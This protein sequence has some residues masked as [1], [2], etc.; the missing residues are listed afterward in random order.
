MAGARVP[1]H[2]GPKTKTPVGEAFIVSS[3]DG[4]PRMYKI[5]ILS[6]SEKQVRVVPS[7]A[8]YFRMNYETDVFVRHFAPSRDDAIVRW[9]AELHTEIDDYKQ[10]IKLREKQ[11][12]AM[13]KD[14]A[15]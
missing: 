14:A 10:Q 9:Q 7:A 3:R 6:R 2:R 12:I 8:T 11:L 13:P 1:G 15:L 4:V 5:V